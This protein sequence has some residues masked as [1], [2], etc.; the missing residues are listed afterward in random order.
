MLATCVQSILKFATANSTIIA[1]IV[2]LFLAVFHEQLRTMFL[3]PKLEVELKSNSPDCHKISC[4]TDEDGKKQFGYYFRIRVM[5]KGKTPAKSVEVFLEEIQEKNEDDEFVVWK[6]FM[7]INLLWTH[8]SK[9]YFPIIP[10]KMYKHCEIGHIIDPQ[11]RKDYPNHYHPE[12]PEGV[13]SICL[14]LLVKPNTGTHLMLPGVYRLKLIAAAENAKPVPATLELSFSGRWNV[15]E[16]DM[17]KDD[18]KFKLIEN[19]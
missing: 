12:A 9:P 7:P 18:A 17:L 4:G 1:T 16:T 14:E 13:C 5:N 2:A 6:K 11:Q 15:S 3:K 19:N 10:S 8:I